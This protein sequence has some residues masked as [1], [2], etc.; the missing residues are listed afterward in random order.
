M[1]IIKIYIYMQTWY[2]GC[3]MDRLRKYTEVGSNVAIVLVCILIAYVAVTRY[4]LDKP[5]DHSL[6]GARVGSTLDISGVNWG[7]SNQNVVL[8]LSTQCHFCSESAPF[9]RKLMAAAQAKGAPVVAVLPQTVN[10]SKVY[11]QT[12][13]LDTRYVQQVPL[14][15]I[16]VVATPTVLL[17]DRKGITT[18]VWVGKLS[19]SAQAEVLSK[20]Q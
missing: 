16:G 15:K 19:D 14:S 20:V 2:R 5:S 17:T 12:M 13:G 6:G 9:Y 11:L 4:I 3:R 10:Q 18:G 7:A 8:A 1:S